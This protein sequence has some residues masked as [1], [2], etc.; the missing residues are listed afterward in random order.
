MAWNLLN[1]VG[2]GLVFGLGV[3]GIIVSIAVAE[4]E[5]EAGGGHKH[6]SAGPKP[7]DLCGEWFLGGLAINLRVDLR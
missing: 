4:V 2:L 7:L 3:V 6:N 1:I 5:T